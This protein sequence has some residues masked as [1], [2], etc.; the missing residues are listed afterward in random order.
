MSYQ[1]N[2]DYYETIASTPLV[3]SP[4]YYQHPHQL[5]NAYQPHQPYQHLIQPQKQPIQPKLI[6]PKPILHKLEDAIRKNRKLESRKQLNLLIIV[7]AI[8]VAVLALWYTN[9]RKYIIEPIQKLGA[10]AK[11]L[12]DEFRKLFR[13][14]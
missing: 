1:N 2:I 10:E 12:S 6:Q 3:I 11:T 5:I 9:S 14:T 4:P 8:V 7:L 13:N